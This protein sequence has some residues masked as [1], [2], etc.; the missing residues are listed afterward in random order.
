MLY[1]A[2]QCRH[3]HHNFIVNLAQGVAVTTSFS[4]HRW[5]YLPARHNAPLLTVLL[6]V[7]IDNPPLVLSQGLHQADEREGRREREREGGREGVRAREKD[8]RN[9]QGTKREEGIERQI[10][11]REGR[12]NEE[13]DGMK[14]ERRVKWR[15]IFLVHTHARAHTHTRMHAHTHTHAHARPPTRMYTY[16]CISISHECMETH[17]HAQALTYM[18]SIAHP[19]D[20]ICNVRTCSNANIIHVGNVSADLHL[21]NMLVCV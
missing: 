19:I 13:R 7:N 14:K 20:R 6:H 15:K 16:M 3:K 10:E 9:K 5:P 2:T 4:P 8:I 12:T 21:F 18:Y 1:D 11:G 17:T